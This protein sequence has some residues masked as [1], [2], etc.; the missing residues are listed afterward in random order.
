MVLRRPLSQS[1]SIYHVYD[2]HVGLCIQKIVAASEQANKTRYV[3]IITN[4]I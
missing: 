1:V 4:E 3:R 2:L